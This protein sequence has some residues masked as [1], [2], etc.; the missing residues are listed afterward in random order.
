MFYLLWVRAEGTGA[1]K[2]PVLLQIL[3]PSLGVIHNVNVADKGVLGQVPHRDVLNGLHSNLAPR[4]PD[5]A[6]W[7]TRVVKH[8]AQE[9]NSCPKWL[10]G[11]R[12]E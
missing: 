12:S 1:C 10:W 2:V 4:E 7:L 9:V 8:R 6:V 11:E 3:I 5:V